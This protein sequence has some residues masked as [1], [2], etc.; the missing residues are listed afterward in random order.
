MTIRMAHLRAQGIS[1][2]VFEADAPTR[3]DAD[4][5][6]LLANLTARARMENLRIDKAALTFMEHGRITYF[7]TPDLVN[8]LTGSGVS[9]WTH[10]LTV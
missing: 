10:S 5:R 6:R 2:A 9:R 8:Y 1:F 4:R 7:G 3:L